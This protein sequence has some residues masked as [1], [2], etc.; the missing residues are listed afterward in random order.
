ME[1]LE[2]QYYGS[3]R[4]YGFLE[5]TCNITGTVAWNI[6]YHIGPYK[7]VINDFGP[8]LP[9]SE[10]HLTLVKHTEDVPLPT[11]H[12]YLRFY[13]VQAEDRLW[14]AINPYVHKCEFCEEVNCDR[15]KYSEGL[16]DSIEYC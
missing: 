3:L 5:D 7:M 16:Q 11:D 8:S 14:N 2:E 6:K 9:V 15:V 12:Y 10:E 4:D 1:L 13:F